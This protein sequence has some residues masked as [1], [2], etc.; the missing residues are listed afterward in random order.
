M[1]AVRSPDEAKR[2][3]GRFA[4]TPPDCGAAHLH[5]GYSPIFQLRVAKERNEKQNQGCFISVYS[6][7]FAEWF[8][9]TL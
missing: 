5:P 4:M 3:P 2:N 9:A 6:R 8:L 1:N 7:S